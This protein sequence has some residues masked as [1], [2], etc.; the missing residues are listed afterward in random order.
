MNIETALLKHLDWKAKFINA[1][2]SSAHIDALVIESDTCCEVGEWLRGEGKTQYGHL[3]SYKACLNEH[4]EFHIEA[5]KIAS[6]INAKQFSEAKKLLEL[7]SDFCLVAIE[8]WSS[9]T[10]LKN[11]A[12]EKE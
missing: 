10:R 12:A 8:L 7:D 9:F 1:A 3:P 5:S 11:E 4:A 6:A 2:H